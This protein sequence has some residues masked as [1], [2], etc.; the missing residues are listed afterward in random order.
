MK[1]VLLLS[2]LTVACQKTAPEGERKLSYYSDDY[3]LIEFASKL[4]EEEIN[5]NRLE[6]RE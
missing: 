5:K 3:V 6:V 2:L 4:E 1:I